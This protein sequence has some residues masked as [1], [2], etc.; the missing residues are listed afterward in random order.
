MLDNEYINA[1]LGGLGSLITVY[2]GKVLITRREQYKFNNE[3]LESNSRVLTSHTQIISD[4]QSLISKMSIDSDVMREKII[5][6]RTDN[7]L[8]KDKISEMGHR[9]EELEKENKVIIE[10]KAFFVKENEVL[11]LQLE[12]LNLNLDIKN[13]VNKNKI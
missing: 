4:L 6:L 10:E 9:V 5:Q 2:L 11:R 13:I 12:N 3:Q 1:L 8:L 7:E